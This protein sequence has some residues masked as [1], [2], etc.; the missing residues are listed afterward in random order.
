MFRKYWWEVK[1][2]LQPGEN[3]LTIRFASP[4][5][6]VQERMAE[7][8]LRG[9]SQAIPGGPYLRKAPCQWGW[10]WGPMPRPSASGK[11]CAWKATRARAWAR[12]ICANDMMTATSSSRRM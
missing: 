4:V 10:D 5:C 11:T 8:E 7:R 9:V 2:Q 6:Y 3:T 1:G 12:C